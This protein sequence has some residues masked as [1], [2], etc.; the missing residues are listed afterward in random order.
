LSVL[1][2]C[3][4]KTTFRTF[5]DISPPTLAVPEM[6]VLS[7]STCTYAHGSETCHSDILDIW[8]IS[9][10]IINHKRTF[11]D[12]ILS[13]LAKMWQKSRLS[14]FALL[15]AHN[16]GTSCPFCPYISEMS[17]R[18][19]AC[20][21][22]YGDMSGFIRL[23]KCPNCGEY[24]RAK[25]TYPKFHTKADIL[26]RAFRTFRVISPYFRAKFSRYIMI[27]PDIWAQT[28]PV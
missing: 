13:V 16:P 27:K 14:E 7:R 5:H 20:R 3:N 25:R 4:Y 18:F 17:A 22:T 23:S 15:Y 2:F 26:T 6:S 28:R 21:S 10:N 1:S 12:K 24:K 11:Q 9:R 8:Y 19:A